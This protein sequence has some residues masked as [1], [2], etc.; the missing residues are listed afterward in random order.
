MSDEELIIKIKADTDKATK[1]INRLNTEVKKLH[2]TSD[3]KWSK[4]TKKGFDNISKSANSLNTQLKALAV[5]YLS[6]QTAKSLVTTAADIE[7]GFLGVAK[8]TGLAGEALAGLKDSILELSTKM[9]GISIEELQSIA[10]TAG[11]LGIS[12]TEN[13]LEFTEVIAKIGATT[14]L[15]AEQAATGMAKLGQSMKVDV[16][17]FDKLGS[18]INE[19]SNTTTATAGDLLNLG[20][21]IA[22][23]GK[24]FGLT[25]DEVLGLSATLTDVGVS[26]ELGGT[27]ISKVMLGMTKDSDAFAKAVGLSME[28]FSILVRDKP[29]EALQSFIG[30]LGELDKAAKIKALDDL[31][32]TSSGTVQTMLKL[33]GATDTLTKN[34][35]T[36]GDEWKRNT[37]LQKEYDVFSEGFNAQ[38]EKVGNTVKKL[39]YK[40]GE[41]LLPALKKAGEDFAKWVNS[42]DE[43]KLAEFGEDIAGVATALANVAGAVGS[44]VTAIGSFATSYPTLSKGLLGLIV[45][46]KA[47]NILLPTVGTA[48]VAMGGKSAALGVASA[49]TSTGVLSLRAALVKVATFAGPWGVA[50]AAMGVAATVAFD[51]YIDGAKKANEATNQASAS[52][53]ASAVGTDALSNSY[54]KLNEQIAAN[55][56]VTQ[57][58]YDKVEQNIINEIAAT[59]QRIAKME[60]VKTKTAEQ[61][62]A[63][64]DQAS[65]L[66]FL[67]AQL[68]TLPAKY[69]IDLE[70]E[71]RQ[72]EKEL[73]ESLKRTEQKEIEKQLVIDKQ[74]AYK[75]LDSFEKSVEDKKIESE[76][77]VET[78]NAIADVDKAKDSM[79]QPTSS[80]HTVEDNVPAVLSDI[81]KLKVTTHSEH[82][83]HIKE[84]RS[85]SEGGLMP[86]NLAVGGRFTGSG[87]VPGYDSTDSDR[88]NAKLT[89]GE[90]VIKRSAVDKIG[91]SA[92]HAI[93]SFKMPKI[94]G[95]A[96]GGLV[97]GASTPQNLTPIN[98]NIG[99]NT[100]GVMGERE[101]AEALQNF[102]NSE[103][104]L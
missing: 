13:I 22:G 83:I 77:E 49:A 60:Q 52:L 53:M 45:A 4:D 79:E 9:A 24:L 28:E 96:E 58:Q 39:A 51:A 42:L 93:N 23:A 70:I 25:A 12:G 68:D 38:M 104:G 81:D 48:M 84:V 20:Q 71:S 31:K 8:T 69:T 78:A 55:G 15:S 11:Q 27:A 29:V 3:G 35:K 89:G 36:A 98:L 61:T 26:A 30:A 32:L 97:G 47:I 33:S 80:E 16:S 73:E 57:E 40:I 19:L 91:V 86:Q 88:V 54:I 95:Y 66:G 64:M 103:A 72:A 92:L 63:I 100:F 14:E 44:F 90:Y 5:T 1:E 59:E 99:G 43:A 6:F 76:L 18:V 75:D 7:E 85:S 50:M 67:Q 34:L 21:R 17:D 41:E 102:I 56:T 82:I 46:L 94:P 101:V 62:A 37:S 87:K 2:K 10:E 74:A 65:K